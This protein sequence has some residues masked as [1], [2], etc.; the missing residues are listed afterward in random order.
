[1]ADETDVN[2]QITDAVTQANL[3]VAGSA[4]AH[5]AGANLQSLAHSLGLSFQNTVS[6]QQQNTLQGFS[7]TVL[8]TWHLLALG[9]AQ[10]GAAASSLGRGGLMPSLPRGPRRTR[11]AGR[12]SARRP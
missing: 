5:A 3:L 11:S 1:M 4:P 9:A 8:E 6:A 12:R 10:S 2:A 7:G